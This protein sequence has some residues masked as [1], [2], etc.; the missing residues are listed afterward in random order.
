[1][2]RSATAARCTDE[3]ITR[4]FPCRSAARKICGFVVRPGRLRVEVARQ[5]DPARFFSS[6]TCYGAPSTCEWLPCNC[7][8]NLKM[9]HRQLVLSSQY[10]TRSHSGHDCEKAD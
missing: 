7:R 3:C 1:M 6:Q 5:L 4:V 8:N 2:G 9:L 10:F